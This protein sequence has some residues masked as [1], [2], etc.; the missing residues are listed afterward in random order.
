LASK[1]TAPALPVT[2]LLPLS[3]PLA[4][5]GGSMRRAAGLAQSSASG[6]AGVTLDIRD[7]GGD[8]AL[9]A[10]E[11]SAAI[12][13]GARMILGPVTAAEV[14]AT[15]AVAGAV[16]VIGF[17]NDP[18][19]LDSGAYVFGVTPVQSVAAILTHARDENLSSLV[20]VV[21]PGAYGDAVAEA[22][23]TLTP[24][25]GLRLAGVVREAAGSRALQARISALSPPPDA[26]LIAHF[27]AGLGS[28]ASSVRTATDARILGT[29]QWLRDGPLWDA[30]LEGAVFAT[31]E[32]EGFATFAQ[33][34]GKGPGLLAA[35]AFDAVRLAQTVGST[36]APLR[37]V[38]HRARGFD[39][40]V[41]PYR[42]YETGLCERELSTLTIRA[43]DVARGT[44]S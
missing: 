9:A 27:G 26:V 38:L 21:P 41:G 13:S 22:V 34:Y 42:L 40:V 5:V 4:E 29:V 28:V 11:A 16:P 37:D 20:A 39:G 43:G 25:A 35:L 31:P 32:P 2:L 6:G 17:S 24:R 10:R 44:S 14:R 1:T 36:P 15:M 8:P 7:T 33:A 23:E 30:A 3:G 12:A 19:L 18:A